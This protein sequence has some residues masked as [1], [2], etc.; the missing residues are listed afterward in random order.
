M[1][2]Y[3]VTYLTYEE[4]KKNTLRL[5]SFYNFYDALEYY[6]TKKDQLEIEC[7]NIVNAWFSLE[8]K[9]LTFEEMHMRD[10]ISYNEDVVKNDMFLRRLVF[11]VRGVRHYLNIFHH[12]VMQ[13][14]N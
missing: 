13:F 10:Y 14:D 3:T 11:Y 4:S 9:F 12:E 6:K 2:L 1:E 5:Y 7:F 8:E